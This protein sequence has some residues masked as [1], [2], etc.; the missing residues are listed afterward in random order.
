MNRK[1]LPIYALAFMSLASGSPDAEAQS[2]CTSPTLTRTSGDR[3]LN[4]FSIT[5]GSN[6]IDMQVNQNAY[7]GS[8]TYFD[9]TASRLSVLP[10]STLSFSGLDWS[11]AWMH[12]YVYVD[13][14]KD[15]VFNTREN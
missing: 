4:S 14:D 9:K 3:K 12:G 2:Y 7:R 11:G 1:L 8:A 5:D 13:Y 6:T 10:G 15:G